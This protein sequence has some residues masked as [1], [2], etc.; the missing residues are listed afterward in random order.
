MILQ[1]L[2]EFY[3]RKAADPESGIAPLGW[4][5]KEFHYEICIDGQGRLLNVKSLVGDSGNGK[6]LLIPK[7]LPRSGSKSYMTTFFLWDHRGYLFGYPVGDAK[8]KGQHDTWCK[9][10]SEL[11]ER[12]PE[13]KPIHAIDLFNSW[14]ADVDVLTEE[15]FKECFKDP[16]N[17]NCVFNVN[18]SM[19]FEDSSVRQAYES[20]FSR[21]VVGERG[22]CLVSGQIG[23]IAR[24][25]GAT[26]ISKDSKFL[27]SF[28]K[29]CGYDSFGKEQAYNAPISESSVFAYTTALNTLLARGSRQKLTIGDATV[30][31]WSQRDSSL[32]N[33]MA[34]F[35]DDYGEKDNP[36]AHT[37]KVAALL[38]S[39]ESGAYLENTDDNRFYVLGLSPNSARISVRFW[40]NGTVADMS[41]KIAAWFADLMIAHGSGKKD[42]LS[43]CRLLCSVAAL[44]KSENVPPNLAGEVMRAILEG[45]PL[46]T[47]LLQAA[48]RRIKTD[49]GDVSYERAKI[50]KACLNRK[51]RF[52]QI[53]E[54]ELTVMLDKENFNVGYCLGRLFAVLE[55]AQEAANNY[56]E[57]NS[58]IRDKYYASASSTPATVFGTL[59]RLKNHHLS[60]IENPGNKVFFERLLGEIVDKLPRFPAHLKMDD[61]GQFAIGYY[62]QRQDFFTKKSED[63]N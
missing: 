18:G 20:E 23:E 63:N 24:I 35:F 48:L 15:R 34:S 17:R 40:H 62:H 39:V 5:R 27:I 46:P 9:S 1:A 6:V 7:S 8:A 13:V 33:E 49:S 25:H 3:D 58:T 56:K 22:R 51:I 50:I 4:E 14:L 60:K 43:M 47:S 36:D 11:A 44:G 10:I 30:V 31:F 12:F 29:N 42:H 28:Q 26:P 16:I 38:K 32:E 45:L 59:M 19:I 61:Q 21:K 52:N 37:E 2:K 53:K 57:L 55:R 41:G 54:K